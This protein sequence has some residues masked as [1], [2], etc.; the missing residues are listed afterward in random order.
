MYGRP[1]LPCPD[2]YQPWYLQ[3]SLHDFAFLITFR[4]SAVKS[5][6]PA[7]HWRTVCGK[8]VSAAK[9][10]SYQLPESMLLSFLGVRDFH[11]ESRVYGAVFARPVLPMP[12]RSSSK[13]RRNLNYSTMTNGVGGLHLELPRLLR[14]LRECWIHNTVQPQTQ[15]CHD[16]AKAFCRF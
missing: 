14:H 16:V 5:F 8:R 7:A 1:S 13:K 4:T 9:S 15:Q 3:D 11:V 2:E 10:I 12:D 6:D